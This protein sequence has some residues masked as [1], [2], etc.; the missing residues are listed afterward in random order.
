LTLE[1]ARTVALLVKDATH[2]RHFAKRG[3]ELRKNKIADFSLNSW[4]I[5]LAGGGRR[6][7]RLFVAQH[8]RH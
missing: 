2:K 6:W 3:P 7:A 5:T 8:T 1:A 4:Q